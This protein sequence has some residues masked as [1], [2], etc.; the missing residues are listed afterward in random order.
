[1]KI[2]KL[3]WTATLFTFLTVMVTSCD[4]T[5]SDTQVGKGNVQLQFKTV[6][7][8][9]NKA[10]STGSNIM[11]QHDSLVVEGSNGSLH[12]DDIRFIVEKFKLEPADNGDDTAE[13]EPEEFEAEPFWIDLP[14]GEDTLSLGNSQIQA[15]LYEELEFEVK[16]LDFDDEEEGE[17][18]EHRALADSI[19]AEFPDWPNEASMVISGSFTPSDGEPQP[20]KV[21]AQAEIEIE[22]EFEP[23]LEVTE[24]NMQQVISVRINPTRWL[25]NEDGTVFDLSQYD[26]DDHQQLLEFEAKFKDGVEEIEV[27][28]EEFDEDEDDDDKDEDDEDD[29]SDE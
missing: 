26:W 7:G 10:F 25:L 1:M 23:P 12:I 19:R 4:T 27:D 16:D 3:L 22:R 5:S 28:E 17:D 13:A 9:F 14:L 6:P 21:F 8:S 29:D 15:G 2:N 24:D 18:Q 20:F 11:T